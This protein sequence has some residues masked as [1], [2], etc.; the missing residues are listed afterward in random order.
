MA[1]KPRLSHD[2]IR[3]NAALPI[4]HPSQSLA[5]SAMMADL[6]SGAFSKFKKQPL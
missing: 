1:A 4:K 5:P 3:K 2:T 6:L